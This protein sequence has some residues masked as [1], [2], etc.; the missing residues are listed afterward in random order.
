[1][2]SSRVTTVV[3]ALEQH[4]SRFLES[5]GMTRF[6][7]SK[8]EPCKKEK[9]ASFRAFCYSFIKIL[10]NLQPN[11]PTKEWFQKVNSNIVFTKIFLILL[12]V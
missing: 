11:T 3:C 4:R 5:V 10:A 12:V 6:F 7:Y 1:M 8:S 9:S 2:P